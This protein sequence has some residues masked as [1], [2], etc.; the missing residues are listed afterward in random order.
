MAV[1]PATQSSY[2]TGYMHKEDVKQI[3]SAFKAELRAELKTYHKETLL[4]AFGTYTEDIVLPAIV[5]SERNIKKEIG[6]LRSDL[7]DFVARQIR[8]AKVEIIKE[9]S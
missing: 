2:T 5:E 6:K 3:R 7:I 4:P 1:S 9:I 8:E